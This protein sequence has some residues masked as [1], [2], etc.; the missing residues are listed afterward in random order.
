MSGHVFISYRHDAVDRSYVERLVE[1][2]SDAGLPV[3]FDR[4]LITG[5]RWHSVIQERIDTCA[6]FVVVMTSAADAS[7]WVN[8]E[9]AQAEDTGKPIFPL[10]LEGERF[11]RLADLQYQDVRGGLLPDRA[12]IDRLVQISGQATVATPAEDEV[13][14]GEWV[15]VTMPPLGEGVKE[16]SVDRW[17][18]MS[19]DR[20][21]AGEPLV[22][23]STDG[24]DSQVRSPSTGTVVETFV[25]EGDPAE[26]GTVLAL[27]GLRE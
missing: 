21:R 13:N 19:G 15:E 26:V 23:I 3:W 6:A 5:D 18:K 2:M 8:R 17:L 27:I 10:L 24:V 9:I 20:V 14:S 16:G 25:G 7:P 22:E 12:F 1:V 4:Q 11:F